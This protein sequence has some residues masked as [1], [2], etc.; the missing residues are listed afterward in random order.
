MTKV[1]LA[2]VGVGDVAQRDYL[3]E[4]HRLDSRAELTVVCSRTA[5]R[6]DEVAV[7]FG[8]DRATTSWEEAVTADDVDAVLNLTPASLHADVTRAAVAAGKHVYSEKPV[9]ASAGEAGSIEADAVRHGVV[10]VAAPS[11]AVFPQVRR[12]REILASGAL[13]KVST[14][15]AS[16]LAGIPPW[17]GYI[18]DPSPYF[19]ADGGPL[20]DMAVY[21]LHALVELVG[22]VIRVSA[23]SNRSRSGFVPTDGPMAGRLIPVDSD[24]NWLL[25]LELDGGCIASVHAT[26]AVGSTASP[27]LEIQ[28]DR[29]T[30]ALSLL[31]GSQPVRLL[32]DEGESEHDVQHAR[33]AGPDHLLGVEHLLDCIE[34]RVQPELTLEKASHVLATL[35]AAAR[36][37]ARGA[38]S[39]VE[40][41]ASVA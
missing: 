11:V 1:R 35:E 31:D 32:T 20:P 29:G 19:A 10:V 38:V 2:A 40:E 21:P 9:A 25:L 36:S 28:G 5:A 39:L 22:R 17:E 14:A 23:M 16:A 4:L 41:G 24:D 12:A 27:E 7:R 8:A 6:A 3:P 34:R 13:G 26:Y 37:A 30:L 15:R 18:S 33:D